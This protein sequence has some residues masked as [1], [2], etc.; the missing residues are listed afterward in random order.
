MGWIN[1]KSGEI[2]AF[3]CLSSETATLWTRTRRRAL[4]LLLENWVFPD[5]LLN[6]LF[7]KQS[8]G[9]AK[10]SSPLKRAIM[11]FEG[12]F[13]ILQPLDWHLSQGRDGV[14]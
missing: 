4:V 6:R 12:R 9:M 7:V 3:C 8:D 13:S 14:A 10:S 11:R 5:V 1:K 2:M